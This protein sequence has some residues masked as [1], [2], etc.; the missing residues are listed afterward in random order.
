MRVL[1]KVVRCCTCKKIKLFRNII[2]GLQP[3]TKVD[4]NVFFSD[5]WKVQI[6]FIIQNWRMRE[7][8]KRAVEKLGQVSGKNELSVPIG[9]S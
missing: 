7:R 5:S 6:K 9:Y 1:R 3:K 8:S 4:K 2:A